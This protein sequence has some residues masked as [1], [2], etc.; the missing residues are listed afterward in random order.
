MNK[1]ILILIP[2]SS[3]LFSCK[4]GP[5]KYIIDAKE[6]LQKANNGLKEAEKIQTEAAR[7]DAIA[8]WQIFNNESDN[9]FLIMENDL[10]FIEGTL[11]KI[12][13]SEKGKITEDYDK[14]KGELQKLK[15]ILQQKNIEFDNDFKSFGS[16]VSE[17]N[18]SFRREYKND[19]D[20]LSGALKEVFKNKLN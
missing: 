7:A 6:N 8:E 16:E 15:E 10:K 11:I 18:V 1:I 13:K 12:N 2:L 9:S 17:K 4:P 5:E 14:A 20:I 3:F 19:I